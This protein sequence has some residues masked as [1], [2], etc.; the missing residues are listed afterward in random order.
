M[1]LLWRLCILSGLIRTV[2]L[3]VT[4]QSGHDSPE[5]PLDRSTTE[6]WAAREATFEGLATLCNA[7]VMI[8]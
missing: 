8:Q 6:L 4:I 3:N 2:N 7:A 1:K 5:S